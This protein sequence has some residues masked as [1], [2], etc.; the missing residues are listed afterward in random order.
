MKKILAL[1][2]VL[3][4][5]VGSTVAFAATDRDTPRKSRAFTADTEGLQ[6]CRIYRIT[7][8]TTGANAVF[9]LYDVAALEE[10]S[11]TN[12]KV[13]GGEATSGDALPMYDFGDEGL[14]F[15][16]ALSVK[17]TSCV[18]VIEYD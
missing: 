8:Q 9:G 4:L 6:S 15:A 3:G 10:T 14:N 13:E 5:L 12:V 11:A 7:G 2:I 16:T 17:V 18:V 1:L